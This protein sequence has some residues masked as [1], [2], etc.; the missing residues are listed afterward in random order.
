[1]PSLI[2]TD[3]FNHF[4]NYQ[5]AVSK[6]EAYALSSD[7]RGTTGTGLAPLLSGRFGANTNVWSRLLGPTGGY[8]EMYLLRFPGAG[9]EEA[10]TGSLS[11]FYSANPRFKLL[12]GD[13][14]GTLVY[15][16]TG[17]GGN[18]FSAPGVS[19]SNSAFTFAVCNDYSIAVASFT[20]SALSTL[21]WFVYLGW[22]KNPAYSGG[23]YPMNAVCITANNTTAAA[24]HI[25]S[26]NGTTV[27]ALKTSGDA[28]PAIACASATPGAD[29]IQIVLRENDAG[30]EFIG[31]PYNLIQ[32]PST[33]NYG[34]VYKNTSLQDPDGITGSNMWM[35]VAPWGSNRLA[36]RIY[37]E[38]I[39]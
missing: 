3:G 11:D 20:T 21:S 24:R 38:G 1:M 19:P 16:N 25:D 15:T 31:E 18:S 2:N 5:D 9:T 29:S 30:N 6:G 33:C 35:P 23:N 12:W 27:I 39:L 28:N 26:A 32:V 4:L 13:F 7:Y 37:T 36:M 14:N 17:N 10:K 8:S 34:Q 22:L